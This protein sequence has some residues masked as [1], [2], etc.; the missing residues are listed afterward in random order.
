[1]GAGYVVPRSQNKIT[2]EDG[3]LPEL[4]KNYLT[5]EIVVISTERADRP[6]T[7]SKGK[8]ACPFCPEN[9]QFV[10]KE[11]YRSENGRVRI[12]DNKY[13]IFNQNES[14]AYGI[15]EVVV[16]TDLHEER[17][18]QFC[19]EDICAVFQGIVDR[20]NFYKEN[21]QIKYVQIFKNEGERAGA[22]I[23]HSHWQIVATSYVPQKQKAIA[24]NANRYHQETSECYTCYSIK[25]IEK[26]IVT[27]NE[28][29]V[30][31]CPYASIYPYEINIVSKRHCA[32]LKNFSYEELQKLSEILKTALSALYN[33]FENLDYNICIYNSLYHDL[34][35]DY[36]EILHFYIQI[37][38]RTGSMAGFEFSTDSHINSIYPEDV[39][40]KLKNI[41]NT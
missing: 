17:L 9:S 7:F 2:R 8:S 35:Y 15:H 10:P 24:K 37:V 16:D 36:D 40:K 38:P 11:K 19:A 4:R 22:S 41:I 13:P 23:E 1:M 3:C 28:H 5:E 26:F 31:Y 30:A 14:S 18:H 33:I 21:P 27:E 39:A 25:S 6:V 29:F 34:Q 20:I 32:D 12:F